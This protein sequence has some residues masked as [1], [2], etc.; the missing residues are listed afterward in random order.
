MRSSPDTNGSA[1]DAHNAALPVYHFRQ[2]INLDTRNYWFL[3]RR[4]REAEV[5]LVVR[6]INGCYLVHTKDF[7]PPGCYR[8]MTGGIHFGEEPRAAALRET[9]EETGLEVT[10]ERLL[11]RIDY[12]FAYQDETLAFTSFMFLMKEQGGVLGVRD[13]DEKIT[14]FREVTLADLPLLADQLEALQGAD[15][16]DWGRYRA[17][18]HR[19]AHQLLEN[20]VTN[21]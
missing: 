8:L 5:V 2:E 16:A 12:D 18:A 7:Y 9:Y 6:R 13:A 15:W 19:I 1:L 10:L 3:G 17:P 11:A 20:N 14:A 21:K 4:N